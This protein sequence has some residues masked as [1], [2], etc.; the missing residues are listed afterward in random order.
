MYFIIYLKEKKRKNRHVI[1]KWTIQVTYLIWRFIMIKMSISKFKVLVKNVEGLKCENVTLGDFP[2]IN[3][4]QK[5]HGEKEETHG[6]SLYTST[7]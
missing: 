3:V 6:Y 2:F 1:T 4:I 7:M 5:K